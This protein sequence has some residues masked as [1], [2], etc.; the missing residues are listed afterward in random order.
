MFGPSSIVA[1]GGE[2]LGA[3]VFVV[4]DLDRDDALDP[5]MQFPLIAEHFSVHLKWFYTTIFD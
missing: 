1:T 2:T 5:R 3:A 4:P